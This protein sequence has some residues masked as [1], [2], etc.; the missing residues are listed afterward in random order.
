MLA[1]NCT[2]AILT[3]LFYA[4]CFV[5]RYAKGCFSHTASCVERR[6]YVTMGL[7][8]AQDRPGLVLRPQKLRTSK[9]VSSIPCMLP[10]CMCRCGYL[11]V[12]GL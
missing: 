10:W 1:P 12:S 2:D 11:P 9:N 4:C 8:A 6:S 5:L 3:I 7:H